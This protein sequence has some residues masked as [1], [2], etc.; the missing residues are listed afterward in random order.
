MSVLIPNRL[1][2]NQTRPRE[3]NRLSHLQT[4]M[5]VPIV[6]ST[7]LND[8]S[9]WISNNKGAGVW[10]FTPQIDKPHYNEGVRI[11]DAP[12]I[13]GSPVWN[14]KNKDF[15]SIP[16]TPVHNPWCGYWPKPTPTGGG[17]GGGG[18]GDV[19]TMNKV[20]NFAIQTL[21][22]DYGTLIKLSLNPITRIGS[23]N[24]NPDPE[25]GDYVYLCWGLTYDVDNQI[26]YMGVNYADAVGIK[27]LIKKVNILTMTEIAT[28]V[29]SENPP[30]LFGD[31]NDSTLRTMHDYTENGFFYVYERGNINPFPTRIYK[32]SIDSFTVISTITNMNTI[33]GS[34]LY[35]KTGN[36]C[37]FPNNAKGKMYFLCNTGTVLVNVF[38]YLGRISLNDFT[39]DAERVVLGIDDPVGLGIGTLGSTAYNKCT[40]KFYCTYIGTG[41]DPDPDNRPFVLAEVN[42]DTMTKERT[43]IL[44]FTE[45]DKNG[46]PYWSDISDTHIYILRWT[47]LDVPPYRNHFIQ[48][49]NM[50]TMLYVGQTEIITIDG[51]DPYYVYNMRINRD[52]KIMLI[53][54]QANT[55]SD[56]F[57]V[58]REYDITNIIPVYIGQIAFN[59]VNYYEVYGTEEDI[60]T[61]S[62]KYNQ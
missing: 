52:D 42:A 28:L 36:N 29:L 13:G 27:K 2:N 45:G 11:T 49:I 7:P 32:I 37:L 55:V 20:D 5:Y 14:M 59:D 48:V 38:S 19:C 57:R 34:T 43:L 56:D 60:L 8:I 1:Y 39:V 21:A 35:L 33:P 26:A 40:N 58:Y 41:G 24:L 6:I 61:I 44:P 23:F 3:V 18:G 54:C 9:Q 53:G 46:K 17:G 25:S 10:K 50:E 16:I 31:G 22:N 12:T 51:Y 4:Q 30:G 47:S 62:Q 15:G